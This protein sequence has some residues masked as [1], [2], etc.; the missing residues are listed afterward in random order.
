M[1]LIPLS[2]VII[3]K[4]AFQNVC[5]FLIIKNETGTVVLFFLGLPG[6]VIFLAFL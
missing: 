1:I 3:E 2:P 6:T 4:L 5:K